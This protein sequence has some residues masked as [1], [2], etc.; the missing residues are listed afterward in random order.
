MQDAARLE[1]CRHTLAL[2]QQ[3]KY[4]PCR[5]EA[6]LRVVAE[7]SEELRARLG[8]LVGA[9]QQLG[10]EDAHGGVVVRVRRRV[11]VLRQG[12]GGRVELLL[13]HAEVRLHPKR[14]VPRR[15]DLLVVEVAQDGERRVDDPDELPRALLVFVAA[16]LRSHVAHVHQRER[17]VCRD[18][19]TRRHECVGAAQAEDGASLVQLQRGCAWLAMS[20]QNLRLPA[21]EHAARL[22]NVEIVVVLGAVEDVLGGIEAARG[23]L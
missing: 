7:P 22:D 6:E 16:L 2:D 12:D 15:G 8:L 11:G 3:L 9:E 10:L 19:E 23:L 5:A 1:R 14:R 18:E 4:R 21:F 17:H 13:E 20:P